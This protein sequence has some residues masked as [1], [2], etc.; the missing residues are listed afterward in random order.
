V[1]GA[2]ALEAMGSEAKGERQGSDARAPRELIDVRARGGVLARGLDERG[3]AE[4]QRQGH[5][6]HQRRGS[7]GTGGVRAAEGQAGSR[8]D[9]VKELT[10]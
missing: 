8:F 1:A 9:S 3:E 4:S 6:V 2:A 5:A 10:W 7:S